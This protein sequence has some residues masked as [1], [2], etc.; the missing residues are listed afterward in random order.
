[1]KQNHHYTFETKAVLYSGLLTFA[2]LCILFAVGGLAPFGSKSLAV[3][4]ADIQYLDFFSYFK[5]VLSGKNTIGYTFGKTLGG[6]NIAVFSYYLS[7]PFNLLLFFFSNQQLHTFFD[8][9]VALKLTLASVAFS[10][11]S[12]HRF[13]RSSH[14]NLCLYVLI[15]TAYGLCQYNFAQASN[16]MWLDG[17]YML[18]FI[19]LQVYY[20]VRGKKSWTLSFLVGTAILFNWYSAGID[21]LFSGFWFLFECG[22]LFIEKHPQFKQLVRLA[23]RYVAAMILGVLLSAAL[24]FPTIGALRKSTRGSLHLGRLEFL[25]NFSTAFQNY[26]YGS[27]SKLGSVALFC[28]SLVIIL[29]IFIFF[30][31]NISVLKRIWLGALFAGSLLIFYWKPFYRAFSLFQWVSSYDYRYSYVT[32]FALLFL[33]LHGSRAI[34]KAMLPRIAL[35][36]VLYSLC[37]VTSFHL[38]PVNTRANVYGTALFI[39]LTSGLY[40]LLKLASVQGAAIPRRIFAAALVLAFSLD[41]SINAKL[42]IPIYSSDNVA[43][44][45]SYR[46]NQEALISS[47]KNSDPSFYRISQ[48]TTRSF[49][50]SHLTAYYNEALAYNYAS[51]S[52]YTSSP[53]DNQRAFLDRLGYPMC[54]ENMCITNTSILGADSLL[55]VKYILSPYPIQGLEEISTASDNGK[56]IYQNPYA[57]PTAFVYHSE[58][59]SLSDSS[60]NPFEF[61]NALYK[62]L[63]DLPD[64]VYTPLAFTYDIDGNSLNIHLSVPSGSNYTVYGNLPWNSEVNASI[65]ADGQ[66]ITQYACWL[67]PSVFYIPTSGESSICEITVSAGS[68]D[69]NLDNM[70]FYALDQNVLAQ[71]AALANSQK[72]ETLSIEN[73][74][75]QADLTARSGDKLFL[76]VPADDDWD[77]LLNGSPAEV[78][79]IGDCLYGISLS[80]GSNKLSM[81]Y[82]IRYLKPGIAISLLTLILLCAIEFMKKKQF[83]LK[84]EEDVTNEDFNYRTLL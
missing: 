38:H 74:S 5:D 53:D 18:P 20:I 81:A 23:L 56:V 26:T 43:S 82:H 57:L 21:C 52:G 60:Q 19:L 45:Q 83:S 10:Y 31:K 77:I 64:D 35:I 79:L 41:L 16:I 73:G 55:G 44:Y 3:M 24:F 75:I 7:S 63:F 84:A 48:T 25:G 71:C 46:T 37:L 69:F 54:G 32:I 76:S 30:N 40:I 66:F 72:V 42:L 1:M 8:L 65:S 50:G 80:E 2:L 11:F 78:D 51:I 14:E 47:I 58:Q 33:A 36:A 4:D 22:L 34:T 9:V 6:S 28:G 17:V 27:V 13:N 67:S 59:G 29:V 15:S 49:G 68:L 12:V 70:Q 62:Q 61:Q 39:L